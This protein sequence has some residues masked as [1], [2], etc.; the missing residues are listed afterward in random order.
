MSDYLNN[1]AARSTGRA[2]QFRPRLPSLF[3]PASGR[4]RPS[5]VPRYEQED[6]VARQIEDPEGWAAP[7]VESQRAPALSRP[8]RTRTQDLLAGPLDSEPPDQPEQVQASRNRVT[9][10]AHQSLNR[11]APDE[12]AGEQNRRQQLEDEIESAPIEPRDW[13]PGDWRLARLEEEAGT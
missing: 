5:S 13:K 9:A 7:D 11:D 10:A 4:T 2:E 12:G 3:E 8:A 1:L 6:A